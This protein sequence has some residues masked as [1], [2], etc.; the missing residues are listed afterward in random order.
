MTF[1]EA[2]SCD[3]WRPEE[4]QR[5]K[6]NVTLTVGDYLEPT[7]QARSKRIMNTN[8]THDAITTCNMTSL[9]ASG[10]L[11]VTP[12]GWAGGGLGFKVGPTSRLSPGGEYTLVGGRGRLGGNGKSTSSEPPP[13]STSMGGIGTSPSIPG[14]RKPGMV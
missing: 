4:G 9:A 14:S 6:A 10:G 8:T 13:S 1:D 5:L 2:I 7:L 11:S 12:L 3:D